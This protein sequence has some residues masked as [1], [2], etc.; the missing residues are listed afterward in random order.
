M[1]AGLI[2]MMLIVRNIIDITYPE[3]KPAWTIAV[4]LGLACILAFVQI[5]RSRL[6]RREVLGCIA[7]VS[8][9]LA[10]LLWIPGKPIPQLYFSSQV[11]FP[12]ILLLI[13]SRAEPSL[14]NCVRRTFLKW[15]IPVLGITLVAFVR[16][17]PA[18]HDLISYL[19]ENPFHVVAQTVAKS[20]II[21]LGSGLMLPILSLVILGIF[22]VRSALLGYLLAFI[23]YER[24]L[25]LSWKV[26]V[27][28]LG[29]AILLVLAAGHVNE[30]VQRLIWRDRTFLEADLSNITS[31]RTEIWSYY[32]NMIEQSNLVEFLFGRG[33]VWFYGEFR[34][35]AHNDMLNLLVAYGL[36]G[37]LILGGFWCVLL[38]RIAPA[39]RVP[40]IAL[41][42]VLFL[43]N[44]VVF[45]QSNIIFLIYFMG[46]NQAQARKHSLPY[47]RSAS[48]VLDT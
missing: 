9:C 21:L 17:Q 40:T 27:L 31:G 29:F 1:F 36:I 15:G 48:P 37:T 23:V 43:T 10:N 5:L 35:M 33:A 26:I 20:S 19:N 12:V 38:S 7:L 3:E 41:F 11:L 32:F 8:S 34:L 47:F 42:L 13:F 4:L 44:G 28:S 2:L 39:Y 24:Q 22:N 45:H 18:E 25:F 46:I 30:F 16:Q 6:S 14:L